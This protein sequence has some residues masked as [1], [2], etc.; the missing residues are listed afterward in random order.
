L[1]GR[2]TN[3]S[4]CIDYSQNPYLSQ[5]IE[6]CRHPSQLYESTYSFVL[7]GV[8]Y[9]LNKKNMPR[10]VL[11]WSFI[12]LYGVFRIMAEFFRQPDSQVGFL[13][14]GLTMGQLLSIP[15]VLIGGVMVWKK[16][17]AQNPFR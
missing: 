9:F 8:L 2:V 4:W 11:T 15:M 3:V 5:K 13:I 12:T 17:T 6:G 7:F 1:Y 16:L 10:G 14:G